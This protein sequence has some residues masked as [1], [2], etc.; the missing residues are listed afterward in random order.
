MAAPAEIR[1]RAARAL[2]C[3]IADRRTLDQCLAGVVPEPLLT[4]LVYGTLRFYFSLCQSVNRALRRPMRA[5]DHELYCLLL[6]GAYQLFHTRIPRH[7]AINES[8]EAVR[9]LERPWAAALV[10]GVL[11]NL[12]PPERSF[13]H[14]EWMI[15]QLERAYGDRAAGLLVANNE[16]A[17]MAL[18]VNLRRTTP[19]RYRAELAALGAACRTPGTPT[20]AEIGWGP[21]TLILEAPVPARDLPGYREG[22][23][24]VQDAGAQ[25]AARLVTVLCGARP[26]LRI[27]DAC[28][29]PGG[30]LFHLLESL[31]DAR[32]TAL[33]RSAARMAILEAE[34]ERLGHRGF[35]TIVA[36][37]TTRD[38]W[39]GQPFDCILLDAPCTGSGTIRRHPDIKLLRAPRDL[40][41][42]AALQGAMLANLWHMLDADATLV[43]CTC[44]IFPAENEAVVG[45]FVDT[46]ADAVACRFELVSGQPAHPGWQLLP[47]DQNTDGFYYA[48][49]RKARS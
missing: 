1:A 23:V 11:R 26:D 13:E 12:H 38:W 49:L 41:R 33:D 17:P 47:T 24:A 43:Y 18:R 39:D 34:A 30:K 27:L 46:C 7:A 5:R 48:G 20:G 25:M 45:R 6:V 22:R 32:L 35:R 4:E 40:P 31:P 29:A 28:A 19:A 37:A 3:V 9:H 15:E 21:E 2:H 44:S 8:V 42:Y 16:R 36:D 14:P 10:N